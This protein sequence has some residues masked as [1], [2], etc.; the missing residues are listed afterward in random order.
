M[1]TFIQDLSEVIQCYQ[2]EGAESYNDLTVFPLKSVIFQAQS[3]YDMLSSVTI[4]FSFISTMAN[5]ILLDWHN[6]ISRAELQQL[7]SDLQQT[8]PQ[9][10]FCCLISE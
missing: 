3:D 2:E 9:L 10:C 6:S 8:F 7:I 1:Q 5:S 4:G